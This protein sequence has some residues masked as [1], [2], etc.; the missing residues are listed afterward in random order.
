MLDER[1]N[2]RTLKSDL[3]VETSLARA[4]IDKA[5]VL[6]TRNKCG[7]GFIRF[8]PSIDV[9]R[10]GFFIRFAHTTKAR[11]ERKRIALHKRGSGSIEVACFERIDH[12]LNMG[13]R[14]KRFEYALRN[15]IAPEPND[16]IEIGTSLA[17]EDVVVVVDDRRIG[18]VAQLRKWVS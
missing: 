8:G 2:T 7:F 18:I 5:R 13:L 12:N 17:P 14:L 4:G 3:L 15:R 1:L 6:N 9:G 11:N 16:H 10:R